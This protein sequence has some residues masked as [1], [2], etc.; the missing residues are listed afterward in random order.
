MI[1]FFLRVSG[2]WVS[3]FFRS[4]RDRERSMKNIRM[5]C[6]DSLENREE[7]EVGYFGEKF[8]MEGFYSDF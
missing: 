4:R 8:Y 1:R 6:I 7:G 3:G 5:V 2:S